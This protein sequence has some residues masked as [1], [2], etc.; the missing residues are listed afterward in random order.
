MT[1]NELNLLIDFI[2]DKADMH[3]IS[4]EIYSG[5]V[6][7]CPGFAIR[8]SPKTTSRKTN[9]DSN[10][11][12]K[13]LSQG[14]KAGISCLKS[15]AGLFC[16]VDMRHLL[17]SN[18]F[19]AEMELW[20]KIVYD[21]RLNISP[22]SSC[23]CTEPGWFR[24]CFANMSEDTLDLAMKRL[25]AFVAESA[26][27]NGRRKSIIGH[28]SGKKKSPTKWVFRLSSRDREQEDR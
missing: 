6:F 23:H 10:D 16:W 4:D 25:N 17:Q 22:G 2:S 9:R 26:G 27:G 3:L 18:T 11:D 14:L 28:S 24:L 15:N 8:S 7:D 1:R 21:V 19:E 5:R 13:C 12:K 20:K